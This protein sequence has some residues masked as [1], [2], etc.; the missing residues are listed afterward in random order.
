[1]GEDH[2]LVRRKISP[3]TATRTCA[4]GV[5]RPRSMI[6]L[7]RVMELNEAPERPGRYVLYWM[8]QSQRPTGNPA[9]EAAVAFAN[10]MKLPVVVAFGLTDGYPEANA[11]HYAFMLEGLRDTAAVLAERNIAFVLRRGSPDDVAIELAADAALVVCDR[12]YLRHQKAWR[13][14]AARAISARMIQ[15]EGDVV[16]PVDQASDKRET[17]ARTLRPKLAR[18]R[19]RYVEAG[20][21]RSSRP[22]VKAAGVKLPASLDLSDVAALLREL[23]IDHSVPPVKRLRG[24][25]TE[26][27]R[28]LKAF[29]AGPLRHYAEARGEPALE[30]VSFLG[31]YLHFGQISPL[32]IAAAVAQSEAAPDNRTAYLE[33]L[34]VRRELAMNFV[35]REPHYDRYECLPEWARSTL[36]AHRGDRREHRYTPQQLAAADTHDPFWNAAMREMRD[37]GYMHNHM[38]MYWGKKILEWSDTPEAGFAAALALNNKYF[39]CGRDPNS[40]ANVAWCFGLH[41]RP[42]PE[43]PIFGTVR[44]MTA[45]GLRRKI[46]TVGYVRRVDELA[47]QETVQ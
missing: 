16:V 20:R 38:R 15:V 4:R 11:R 17:A 19:D 26:A 30:Q 10:R 6:D 44:S 40:Y 39:L 3:P 45:D 1:M 22:A 8:Q 12:G 28:R 35:E 24:G 14:R 29:L 9:L 43:R 34:I 13:A 21:G 18:L 5:D 25:P 33:E 46:D 23:D 27:G 31:A 37:T 7:T 32:E 36:H 47:R 41:D 42:W 2:R